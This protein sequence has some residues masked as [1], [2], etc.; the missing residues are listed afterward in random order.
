MTLQFA[1]VRRITIQGQQYHKAYTM[2]SIVKYY[3]SLSVIEFAMHE[4]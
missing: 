4:I 1:S 3:D 2:Q